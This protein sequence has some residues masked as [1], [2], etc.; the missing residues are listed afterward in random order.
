M[1]SGHMSDAELP[2][3]KISGSNV[4]WAIMKY[5][6]IFDSSLAQVGIFFMLKSLSRYLFMFLKSVDQ[7]QTP[8]NDA[9]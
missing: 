4:A 7:D 3:Y 9:V 5:T 2:C 1:L 6:W 8:S